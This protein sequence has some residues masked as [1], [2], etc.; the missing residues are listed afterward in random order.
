MALECGL[1]QRETTTWVSGSS[2]RPM[3]TA[4]MCGSMETG[5]RVSS[6]SVSSM[7]QARKSSRQ[8]SYTRVNFT[9]GS[10]MGMDS[11]F[12][13]MVVTIRVILRRGFETDT[14]YGNYRRGIVTSTKDST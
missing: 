11:S 2:E 8:A 6:S 12:G 10:L 14:V 13:Q 7:V 3:G 4:C 9:K 1:E 5:M